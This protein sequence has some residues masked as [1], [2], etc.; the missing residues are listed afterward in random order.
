MVEAKILTQV[1]EEGNKEKELLKHKTEARVDN[2]HTLQDQMKEREKLKE[3]A[4]QE[5]LKEKSAVDHAINKMVEEDRNDLVK[6]TEKTK[7]MQY[8]MVKSLQAKQDLKQ[9][10]KEDEVKT[11]EKIKIYQEEAEKREAEIKIKRA[12]ESAAKEAIFAKLN[13]EE[14]KRRMEKEYIENLRVDLMREEHEEAARIKELKE[15]EKREQYDIF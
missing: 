5:Y 1:K 10:V 9:K 13:D 12:E 7:T 3:E 6:R 11:L 8:F 4:Y 15:A 2:K 14:I